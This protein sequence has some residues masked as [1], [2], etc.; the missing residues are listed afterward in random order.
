VRR[1]AQEQH[2]LGRMLTV[3]ER[4]ELAYDASQEVRKATL[5]GELI[6]AIVY[7][8][9]LTLT[10]IEGKMFRPM[11]VTVVIALAGAT[12]L[13]MT[14]IPA[15]VA[16]AL[17]GKIR[18][19]ENFLFRAARNGYERLLRGSLRQKPVVLTVAVGALAIA[20]VS[21]TGLGSE[22]APK[23][24][25]GALAIQPARIPSI[26]ITASVE[27]SHHRASGREVLTRS[28]H[29]RAD[30]HRRGR[31][32]PMGPNVSDTYIMLKPREQWTKA[33]TQAELAEAME[34]EL[35]HLPGQNFEFS[36]PIELRFNELI[37][38]VRSDVAVKVFGDDLDAMRK[39][40]DEIAKVL[41]TVRASP[42]SRS[43][44]RQAYPCSRCRSTARDRSLRPREDVQD[45]GPLP[46]A[47]PKW[48]GI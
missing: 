44:R 39:K 28:S 41:A 23:L 6:I 19:R 26:G 11:A 14:F 35:V 42:T 47:A 17:G 25:E 43:S 37:S 7:L 8:P 40:A 2:R 21:A 38:G 34:K 30:G 31:H 10:G 12:I 9:I 15:L 33:T 46:S 5:F 3:R 36:Q 48:T 18:E 45:T 22:F 1:F 24:S 27:M 29:L 4:V 32:D 20:G 16:V 13:S